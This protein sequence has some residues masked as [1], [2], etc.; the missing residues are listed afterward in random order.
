MPKNKKLFEAKKNK[1]FQNIDFVLSSIDLMAVK[2]GIKKVTRIE[3]RKKEELVKHANDF[4]LHNLEFVSSNEKLFETYSL[5]VSRDKKLAQEAKEKD[6]SYK[7]INQKKTFNEV[8]DDVRSFGRLLSYPD[9][10]VNE[11]IENV[12]K[13]IKI[14]GS[15]AFRKL[16]A[17]INFLFN[18]QLDGCLFGYRLSF[19][20]PC[21]FGCRKSLEY[22]ENLFDHIEKNS[23]ETALS[24]KE[25][26]KKPILVFLN[27]IL[28]NLYVSWDRRQGFVFD[29]KI[30]RGDLNYS[31]AFFFKTT[32]PEFREEGANRELLALQ[33]KTKE[34]DKLVFGKDGFNIYKG[35]SLLLSWKNKENLRAYLFNFI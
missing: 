19:H 26:L 6:P 22:L 13:N 20:F 12:L 9:C 32:Y 25:Y 3:Y 8:I 5:Y 24:L 14:T 28:S 33:K 31:S 23:P 1:D 10:C 7:I 30:D 16:P 35:K 21:S 29:G 11:Y 18:N 17:K 27:P 34:G 4:N 15:R 2:W